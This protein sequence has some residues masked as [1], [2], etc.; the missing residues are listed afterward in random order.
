ML[1]IFKRDFRSFFTGPIG[2]VFCG[3]FLLFMNV[4]FYFTTILTASNQLPGLFSTMILI[5]TFLIPILT[6]RLLSE[7]KKL[8]TDQL[9]LT[10]PVNV[11]DIVMGKFF[12]ALA[13]F[14]CTLLCTLLYPMIVSM[15]GKPE[16]AILIGNYVAVLFVAMAFIAI[17]LFV[18]SLTENQLVSAVV[19][20]AILLCFYL[21][22]IGAS[23][24]SGTIAGV[25]LSWLSIS[26][27]FSGFTAGIFSLADIVYYISLTGIFLFLTVRMIEKKRWS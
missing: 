11:W 1:A 8:K 19:S 2:Y 3:V 7:E 20:I 25:V 23:L 16:A 6:M 10:A 14:S 26:S 15:F 18:S 21:M 17:C 27:R 13:V 5:L 4:I 22:E 9:L 24:F 12:A